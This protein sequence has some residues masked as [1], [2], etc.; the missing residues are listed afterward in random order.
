VDGV[1]RE[2]DGRLATSVGYDALGSGANAVLA[3]PVML[4][5]PFRNV[6]ELGYAFRDQPWK[7]LDFF[8]ANSAD[9]ALLDLFSLNEQ[10]AVVAGKVNLNSAR[11]EVL[12]AI[13]SSVER[14][15]AGTSSTFSSAQ[16][17]AISVALAS[18]SG[19]NP[20]VNSAD[21][22]SR[23]AGLPNTNFG[24]TSDGAIKTRR[25]AVVRA[26]A[27]NGQTRTW[28]LLVDLVAQSGRYGSSAGSLDKFLVEGE[29]RYWLHLAIDRFTGQVIDQQI[30]LVSE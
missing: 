18:V 17:A 20:L 21:L 12:Q 15:P 3:R 1:F 7:T 13:I 28:N 2:G 24:A 26:L 16:A 30:E 8:S 11:P 25:E 10:P 4:D 19:T 29:R 14:A 27:G 23:T 9:G 5:R 6:G 22:A